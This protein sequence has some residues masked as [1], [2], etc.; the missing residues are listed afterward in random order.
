M[1]IPK[2]QN[3]PSFVRERF[4]NIDVVDDISCVFKFDNDYDVVQ[5]P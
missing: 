4:D 5:N 1:I 2:I 3:I